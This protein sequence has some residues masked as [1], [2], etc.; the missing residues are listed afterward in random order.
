[1]F[2]RGSP[3]SVD[4]QLDRLRREYGEFDVVDEETVV[5]REMYADCRRAAETRALGGAR[6]FVRSG[7]DVA[8]LRYRSDPEV[9]D[10]PGG[11]TERGESFSETATRH[12]CVDAGVDCEITGV[13]RVLRE[14]F[15]LVADG[16]GVTGLW[17]FFEAETDDD[18]SAGEGVLE[19][20][21]FGSGNVPS[22]V[23]PQVDDQ[24]DEQTGDQRTGDQPTCGQRTGDESAADERRGV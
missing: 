12:A 6:V 20:A 14:T 17:V 19:A 16:D 7:N 2:T 18:L 22:A 21:W 10:L 23:D 8:F 15:A 13:S 24:L 3:D 11:S 9:W 1:M 5:S 4:Q